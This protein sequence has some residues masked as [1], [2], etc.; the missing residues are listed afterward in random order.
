MKHLPIFSTIGVLIILLFNSCTKEN[1]S[2]TQTGEVYLSFNAKEVTT[3]KASSS[4]HKTPDAIVISITNSDGKLIEEKKTMPLFKFGE[5]LVTKS[6]AL[7]SGDYKITEYY[8]VDKDNNI[9]YA[10]PK[11]NSTMSEWVENALPTSFSV[12][13][14][15]VTQ[16][17]PET[18]ST[19][20]STPK[21]FGYTTF[22]LNVIEVATF[23]IA[24][25]AYNESTKSFELTSANVSVF[26]GNE[27]LTQQDIDAETSIIPVPEVDSTFTI[28]VRK[29]GYKTFFKTLSEEELKQYASAPLQVN[30]EKAKGYI[31]LVTSQKTQKEVSVYIG[32]QSPETNLLIDW[33]D[34]SISEK[35]A[36][37]GANTHDY[38]QEGEYKIRI[39]GNVSNIVSLTSQGNNITQAD[40]SSATN[41]QEINL[42]D[43]V[44]QTIDLSELTKL[45]KLWLNN[46]KI[47]TL[48]LSRNAELKDVRVENNSLETITF[49][50]KSKITALN[51]RK[52]VISHINI[53]SL[54]ELLHFSFKNT[55]IK[56]INL[57]G[58]NELRSLHCSSLDKLAIENKPNLEYIEI[59][60]NNFTEEEINN[61]FN[62][63]FS[64]VEANDIKNGEVDIKDE[65]TS[66]TAKE[67][68]RKLKEE[69][70]WNIG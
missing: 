53:S 41:I 58:N 46:N 38:E 9:I 23:Q 56:T 11:E 4:D 50:D 60:D 10:A 61:F 48:N 21:A 13:K 7:N 57:S 69:Y 3:K 24:T 39:T 26:S 62:S 45:N 40:L 54:S 12:Q 65:P 27:L 6:L 31:T 63:L 47:Q 14:D 43:N 22:R 36:E 37:K 64:N 17:A 25:F 42:I 70:S 66:E 20:S 18:I 44:L 59:T 55:N 32:L 67:A 34:G 30:L 15:S 29:E 19:E 33:G 49:A 35:I 28:E 52:N 68:K 5:N 8:I 51:I 2:E 16:L 1:L